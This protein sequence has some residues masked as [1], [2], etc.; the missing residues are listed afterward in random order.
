M[1]IFIYDQGH[2]GKPFE[3]LKLMNLKL[4]YET[5]REYNGRWFCTPL[6]ANTSTVWDSRNKIAIHVVIARSTREHESIR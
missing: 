2:L 4:F 1:N 6:L 3:M 5:S